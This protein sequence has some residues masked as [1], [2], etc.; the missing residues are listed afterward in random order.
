MMLAVFQENNLL[1]RNCAWRVKEEVARPKILTNSL[2]VLPRLARAPSPQRGTG[3]LLEDVKSEH[4][5]QVPH[6]SLH[7]SFAL[8]RIFSVALSPS[9]ADS[10]MINQDIKNLTISTTSALYSVISAITAMLAA[11]AL[12]EH[13][14]TPSSHEGFSVYLCVYD[15]RIHDCPSCCWE[16]I[17][18]IKSQTI[19]DTFQQRRPSFAF[20]PNIDKFKGERTKQ[21]INDIM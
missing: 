4:A 14:L 16:I 5:S 3:S 12:R 10:R 21:T 2:C 13:Q 17:P 8:D 20:E 9:L 7:L 18:S 19:S 15:R 6:V 11:S 1:V